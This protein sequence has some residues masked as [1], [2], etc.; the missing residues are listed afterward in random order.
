MNTYG[1]HETSPIDS[2]TRDFCSKA[3]KAVDWTDPSLKRIVRLRLLSD[4]G[5]PAWDVSYCVGELQD[6]TP[7][8]VQLP[9]SQLPRKGMRGA[10]VEYAKK[11]GIHA[12]RLGVFDALST[13]V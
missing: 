5:Y 11:D 12:G 8:R 7:V 1:A 9:F 6:G 10:I 3:E 4:P 2:V 13:L